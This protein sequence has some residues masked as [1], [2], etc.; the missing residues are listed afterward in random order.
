[1][2]A[3]AAVGAGV[4]VLGDTWLV[5]LLAA[6]LALVVTQCAFLGHDG[7]H[8]Q[9]FGSARANEAAGRVFASLLCGLSYGWW[10]GK[11]TRHH[12]A[13]NTEGV[14][15]DIRSKVLSYTEEMARS[16]RGAIAWLT[17]R[18]GWFFF[19]LLLLQG[20]NL[21]VDSTTRLL[22]RAPVK[23]RW[24]DVALIATHWG[25]YLALLLV[26][27]PPGKAAAFLGVHLAVLG[28][29]M[30]AAFAPNH[31][32][33]PIVPRTAKLDFLRRQ[34]LMSRNVRGGALVH[35]AM[36]GLNFQVEH[37][38]F[39][40]MPRPNLRRAQPLVRAYCEAQ[41]IP[42]TETSV[43]GAYRAVVSHLNRVGLFA[44][45]TFSCPLASQLR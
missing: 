21:H 8:R 13:P 23:R 10:M 1:M 30:G 41:Q 34:V 28:V 32:G 36:G 20:A 15:G 25:A 11:H 3:L 6:A 2:A 39:P 27:L 26:A 45:S 37:H 38:L 16:R 19:P 43:V 40:S 18:Q 14:D 44:R 35:L 31:V 9:M 5:L 29:A 12:Q 4:L 24:V 22:S 17:R 33:M 42:Y 7:A